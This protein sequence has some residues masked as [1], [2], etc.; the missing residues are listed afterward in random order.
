MIGHVAGRDPGPALVRE[1]IHLGPGLTR[2]ARVVRAFVAWIGLFAGNARADIH[3]TRP[4]LR[5]PVEG[6][7][8]RVRPVI[9]DVVTVLVPRDLL[10][11]SVERR[12]TGHDE[13]IPRI[14]TER[15]GSADVLHLVERDDVRGQL[16]QLRAMDE[17]GEELGPPFGRRR[18]DRQRVRD[19]DVDGL[20]GRCRRSVRHDTSSSR[21][22]AGRRG[23]ARRRRPPACAHA[24]REL[25]SAR[26]RV[27]L[28]RKERRRGA[29]Q[30]ERRRDASSSGTPLGPYSQGSVNR[31]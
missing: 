19:E 3:S 23:M 20:S 7:P 4:P 24:S 1:P 14:A 30:R 8:G 15:L 12:L 10:R 2:V 18:L 22:R 26:R 21:A 31:G 27:C 16:G 29:P 6:V 5:A 9:R 11:R 13:L 17:P 28:R 25:T